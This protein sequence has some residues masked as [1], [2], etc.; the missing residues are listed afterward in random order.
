MQIISWNVNGLRAVHKKNFLELFNQQKADFFCLQEI[1]A[2]PEQ[3]PEELKSIDS[4][5][6]YFNPAQKKGYSGVAVYCKEKPL[7]VNTKLGLDRFDQ[8]GRF[9]QLEFT[10]F[11][12][13]N[14]YLPHGGREKENL[15]Y[16][17]EC[18]QQLLNHL[19]QIS[20]PLVLIGDFN[21]AHQEIDL[22]RPKDNKNNIMFTLEEREKIDQLLA[23]GFKDTFRLFNQSNGNYTWWPY[24][25]N[26]RARNL[27]WRL[28]YA[29]AS[30]QLLEKIKSASI[31][32][33]VLGSDHCPISLVLE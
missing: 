10:D 4:Y 23:L 25:L 3:L 5:F 12:L 30:Q 22:E 6:S 31:L 7:S 24:R 33:K 15:S 2:A 21:I 13:I 16:K 29:F 20:K 1:K 9:L 26:A 32:R 27:G 17:L 28:D 18:Y 8:E 11:I 14:I 19:S